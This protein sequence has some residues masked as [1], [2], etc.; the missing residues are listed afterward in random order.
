MR[1]HRP[2]AVRE[3]EHLARPHDALKHLAAAVL[4][5][6]ARNV[7]EPGS[8]V[9]GPGSSLLEALPHGWRSQAL[10]RYGVGS[11]PAAIRS[12]VSVSRKRLQIPV[13]VS[14]RLAPSWKASVTR[15]P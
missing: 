12:K 4:E 1:S 5:F 13:N 11:S 6:E 9:S 2:S 8:A 14:P 15:S 10:T 7:F 3:R